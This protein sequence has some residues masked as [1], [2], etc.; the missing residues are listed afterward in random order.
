MILALILAFGALEIA[1][2]ILP[3]PASR[4]IRD[5][6]PAFYYPAETRLRP[7][8]RGHADA[9]RIAVVGDSITHG[10]GCQFYDTYSQ[11]LEALMNLN[12]NQRPVE[13]R[14]WAKG[15][16]NPDVEVRHLPAIEEWRPDILILGV[17]LNDAENLH[18]KT[19]IKTWRRDTLPKPPPPWLGA[20][21]KHT[22]AGSFMYQKRADRRAYGGYLLYYRRLY[23]KE[24]SGWILLER[25]LARFND[26]CKE[27]DIF[28]LP[29]VF[30]LFSDVD[31]YP[32]DWVHEQLAA[33]FQ[34]IGVA[35]LDFLEH[36]RG[37]V[38]MRL[39]VIP[40]VDA[41]P[42]E[43]AHRQISEILFHYLIANKIVDEGY[44]PENSSSSQQHIWNVLDRYLYNVVDVRPEAEADL[45]D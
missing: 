40:H 15:G 41:H 35:H 10:T 4:R 12:E 45:G 36:F 24:H 22:R 27:R 25:A 5:R 32:F 30:P 3:D 33:T 38:P 9:L 18:K 43:I 6:S 44:V 20:I 11:R 14:V 2:R 1:L 39:Q 42:N 21:L 26:F 16:D 7:W 31:N 28:F 37:Q 23:N 19:L 17:C 8:A 34:E 29:L 13:V